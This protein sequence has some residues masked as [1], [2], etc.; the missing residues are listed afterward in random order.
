[1]CWW[2]PAPPDGADPAGPARADGHGHAERGLT[3]DAPDEQ[4]S[5]RVRVP[6]SRGLAAEKRS[7]A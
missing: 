6:L 2:G 5:S 4:G 1:M 3:A 7:D